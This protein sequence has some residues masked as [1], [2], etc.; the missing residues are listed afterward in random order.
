MGLAE[1]TSRDAVLRA[2]REYD[3]LGREAFLAKYHFQKARKF[4]VVHDGREYDSKPLLAA[5]HGFQF[6]EAGP[7]LVRSS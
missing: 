1:I 5:A 4:V 6:P 3:D 2:I 7:L